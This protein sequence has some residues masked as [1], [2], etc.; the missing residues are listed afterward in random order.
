M[1]LHEDSD[2]PVRGTKHRFDD[3]ETFSKRGRRR[4]LETVEETY[5]EVMESVG[6]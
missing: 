6:V 3:A 4:R 1:R 5:Q 2:R